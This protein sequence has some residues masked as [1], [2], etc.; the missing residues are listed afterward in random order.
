MPNNDGPLGRCCA[1]IASRS[2]HPSKVRTTVCVNKAQF[3]SCVRTRVHGAPNNPS[4]RALYLRKRILLANVYRKQEVVALS[5]L[6]LACFVVFVVPVWSGNG[7]FYCYR[8]AAGSAN[9]PSFRWRCTERLRS[10]G[11][12]P[13][14]R[15]TG[16]GF[17]W[18]ECA[19]LS[20]SYRR[21]DR[22]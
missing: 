15:C 7:R 19:I 20:A 11:G 2:N 4:S 1:L 17:A 5:E 18:Q 14:G 9:E 6:E 10:T 16:A 22:K 12:Q 3:V 13:V 8:A 21:A